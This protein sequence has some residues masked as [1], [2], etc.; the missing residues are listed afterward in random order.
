[1]RKTSRVFRMAARSST[2]LVMGAMSVAASQALAQE[3]DNPYAHCL[4]HCEDLIGEARAACR[5]ECFGDPW[6]VP[7]PGNPGGGDTRPQ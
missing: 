1:M 3:D 2:L 6:I 4:S 7:P 5:Q